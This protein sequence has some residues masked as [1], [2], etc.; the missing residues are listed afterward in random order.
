MNETNN[1]LTISVYILNITHNQHVEYSM[2]ADPREAQFNTAPSNWIQ[3][4]KI[5]Q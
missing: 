1:M 4:M 5:Q 3:K 2:V